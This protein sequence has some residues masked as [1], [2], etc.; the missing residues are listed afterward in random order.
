M[1]F[2]SKLS[3]TV[4]VINKNSKSKALFRK[5]VKLGII[6]GA[7]TGGGGLVIVLFPIILNAIIE[8]QLVIKEGNIFTQNW[9]DVPLPV[10]VNI[11]IWNLD[12]PDQF[13]AG[14]KPRMR[15]MGPYSYLV[16]AKHKIISWGINNEYVKYYMYASLEFD[17]YNSVGH[18]SD[19]LTLLNPA[20]YVAAGT[21]RNIVDKIPF[22]FTVAPIIY[23][24]M[25]AFFLAHG[26]GVI[27]ETTA[28]DL[29]Q[30][31]YMSMIGTID[32][33]IKPIKWLGIDKLI[34]LL[35]EQ[36][37][38]MEIHARGNKFGLIHAIN[39]SRLGP[40]EMWTGQDD[41]KKFNTFKSWKG[42]TV[43][44]HWDDPEC[45]EFRGVEGVNFGTYL[46][47]KDKLYIFVPDLG[48]SLYATYKKFSFAKAIPSWRYELRTLFQS[49]DKN[50][51]NKC[52]CNTPNDYAMCD[53]IFD[54]G[55][56]QFW[57]PIAISFPHLL[58]ASDKI[59]SGVEGL[60]PDIEK[61]DAYIDV[62]PTI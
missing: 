18:Y 3:E 51:E 33:L 9:S 48:R 28:G 50:P 41:H 12:N 10:T 58:Y 57:L 17:A 56:C 31:K 52:Y 25:N 44:N 19:K 32:T 20:T 8:W 49:P 45:N 7:M 23:A 47:K 11:Y 38:L 40:Y 61:H 14:A 24:F 15:E 39:N 13:R 53:G 46:N 60:N 62:N 16:S 43:L 29:L 2:I 6:G 5:I 4:A 27:L 1:Q 30:G 21:A 34:P 54:L 36:L 37:E 59:Q 35:G 22:A 26:E 55:P 42:K